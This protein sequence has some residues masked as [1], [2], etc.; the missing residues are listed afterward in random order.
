M[1]Y[2]G[3][4][5]FFLFVT[6]TILS[7]CPNDSAWRPSAS[8]TVNSREEFTDPA[9]TAKGL[10][11]T[12]LVHNTGNTSIVGSTVTIRVRTSARE[13]LQTAVSDLKINPG[14]KIALTV[15]LNY[16]DATETLLPDGLAV[17]DSFFE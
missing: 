10:A 14:G 16:I 9:G 5:L 8:V 11:V 7:S 2:K 15:Q 3:T 12:L 17:Y 6:T 13:Y 1:S 4:V